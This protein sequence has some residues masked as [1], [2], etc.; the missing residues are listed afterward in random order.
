MRLRSA[1]SAV[2]ALLLLTSAAT[3]AEPLI[4]TWQLQK[5]ELNGEKKESEPITLRITPDGDRFLFAFSVP[6]NNI[7]FVSMTYSAKLDGTEADVKNARGEKVGTIRITKPSASHYKLIL[8]GNNHPESSG[9]LTVSSDGKTL[10]S[11][12][13]S[14]Q[15]GHDSRL[16]QTFSRE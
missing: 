8:K 4:G 16:V 11:E 6:V 2:A 12:A 5:Q 15:S 9:L 1:I 7:D 14:V 10:T 13:E 3:A